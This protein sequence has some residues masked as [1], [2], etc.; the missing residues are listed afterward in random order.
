MQPKILLVDDSEITIKM[1]SAALL[2]EDYELLIAENGRQ[3]FDIIDKQL[4]DLI[5]LDLALPDIDGYQICA[6]LRKS[7]RT[8]NIPIIILTSY[9]DIK[10]RLKAF[11]IGADD[12]I[13]K[14]FQFEELQA[15][16]KY[17]LNW[18]FKVEPLTEKSIPAYKI[19]VFSLRGGIGV[20]TL[21]VNLAAGLVKLWNTPSLLVDMAFVNGLSSTMLN[22]SLRSTW[23]DV[24]R[25]NSEVIEN[26]TL[27]K[28]TLHHSCGL[29]LVAAPR[30]VEEAETISDDH[31]QRILSLAEK[32]YDYIIADLPHDFS[33]TTMVALDTA[34]KILLV[35]APDM[36]SIRCA[37]NALGV[38][39][40]LGYP[41]DKVQ[42]V[43][44]TN[45]E[46]SGLA[47]KD[48]E[49]A[50]QKTVSVVLPNMKESLWLALNL[51]KPVVLDSRKPESALFEDLAY[52]WSRKENKK[53]EPIAPSEAYLRVK[54]RTAKRKEIKKTA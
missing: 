13:K 14:P 47:R 5:L 54:E 30:F 9:S 52:F 18:A 27:E 31:V 1:V 2:T 17:H 22:L 7:N 50:L 49:K 29:D 26:D 41:E 6:T 44:N 32:K 42:L 36:G 25:L 24:G 8:E 21:A 39:K 15:R 34:D 43:M 38:F 10:N 45:F 53:I 4:P 40:H 51:G 35:A 20:S 3:A 28:I 37:S 19:A 16:I 33:P 46:T 48:I 12:F 11:E 23:S